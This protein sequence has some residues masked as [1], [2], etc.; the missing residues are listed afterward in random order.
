MT[1]PGNAR[2]A[3][4][5][6]AYPDIVVKERV[7]P[8][9]GRREPRL[10]LIGE[11]ETAATVN[12]EEAATWRALSR[13]GAPFALYVPQGLL[14]Q[15]ERLVEEQGLTGVA[16]WGYA[17]VFGRIKVTAGRPVAASPSAKPVGHAAPLPP[18]TDP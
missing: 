9:E 17:Y 7:P 2:Q 10:L 16:L 1:N 8:A 11:V 6:R 18:A 5:G 15:A 12:A 14:A 13:L 4:V 3:A